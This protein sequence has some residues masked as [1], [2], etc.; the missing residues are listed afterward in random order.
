MWGAKKLLLGSG[1][2]V[3]L[4]GCMVPFESDRLDTKKS[5]ALKEEQTLCEK[6]KEKLNYAATKD[7]YVDVMKEKGWVKYKV[8]ENGND[9]GM[10]TPQKS[11]D[12]YV[13]TFL[14]FNKISSE[15][16]CADDGSVTVNEFFGDGEILQH[17]T[18]DDLQLKSDSTVKSLAIQN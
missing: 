14:Y 6:A 8:F 5:I 7:N 3:L 11:L 4:T 18:L 12:S 17:F 10:W 2:V 16:T 13:D 9:A 1:M 15:V